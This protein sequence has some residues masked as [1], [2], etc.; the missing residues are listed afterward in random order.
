MFVRAWDSTGAS[1]TSGSF[2]I[3]VATNT[4]PTPPP[5]AA[6]YQAIQ[7]SSS[8]W[9]SCG[10]VCC[11]G[12]ASDAW[13]WPMYQFQ[14]APSLDGA[15]AEFAITGPAY[16]DA[17]HWYKVAAQNWATNYLWD[18]WTYLDS[19]SFTAQAVEFDV[20]T[21]IPIAGI[22]RKFMFG[23]QCNYAAGVWDG[24]MENPSGG[25]TWIPTN[26]PCTKLSPNSWHHLLWYFKR[27]GSTFDQLQY[28][29]L[30]VDG[31]TY[32]VNMLE[33][34]Q[35]TSWNQVLGIQY[36]QDIGRSGTGFRQWVDKVKLSIW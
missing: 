25:G 24:W 14:A 22:N 27:V 23:S 16:A 2:P 32:N 36:Q 8:G 20:F 7:D 28:V 34:S 10:T 19:S 9:G 21:V 3:T 15:S 17:L 30:T 26:I 12:G 31:V 1:G 29:S 18:S 11:A 33:P 35:V 5:G 13:S 6:V 4:V